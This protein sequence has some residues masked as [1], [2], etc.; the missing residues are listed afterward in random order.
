MKA[1][2]LTH[3]GFKREKNEDRYLISEMADDFILLAVAD[4]V[5]GEV[6]GEYALRSTP[7]K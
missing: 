4:G 1:V 3:R 5:G 7:K 6:A 2:G